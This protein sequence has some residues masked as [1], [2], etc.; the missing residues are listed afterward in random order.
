MTATFNKMHPCY[1]WK[2]DFLVQ[3]IEMEDLMKIPILFFMLA[4]EEFQKD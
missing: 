3:K 2:V 1:H 4:L